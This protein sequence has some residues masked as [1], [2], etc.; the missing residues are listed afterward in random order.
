[1]IWGYHYFWKHPYGAFKWAYDVF[2]LH[3]LIPSK[4]EWD[5]IPTDPGPSKLRDRA[6]RYSGFQVF[7]FRGPFSG[8][9]RR[10]LGHL[11]FLEVETQK[12][13]KPPAL[14]RPHQTII[15]IKDLAT[16][17]FMGNQPGPFKG[18]TKLQRH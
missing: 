9:S 12:H 8:S 6:I 3:L 17:H 15:T 14:E 2:V 16:C 5:R 13:H 18:T 11:Q 10:F 7:R 1:M 4:I